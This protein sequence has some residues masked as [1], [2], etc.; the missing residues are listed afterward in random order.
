MKRPRHAGNGHG[1]RGDGGARRR[2]NLR[3]ATILLLVGLAALGAADTAAAPGV[4]IQCSLSAI[5]LIDSGAS[6]P[7]GGGSTGPT[8]PCSITPRL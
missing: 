1:P 8:P 6:P 7:A 3:I 4:S 2:S 5:V